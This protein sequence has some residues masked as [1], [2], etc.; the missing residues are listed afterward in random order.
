M[1]WTNPFSFLNSER[2][3]PTE[4]MAGDYGGR[5]LLVLND[6]A[7]VETVRE[8]QKRFG[9]EAAW[10]L[11]NGD[12]RYGRK[13]VQT[14]MKIARA[15]FQSDHLIDQDRAVSSGIVYANAC[16]FLK[17]GATMTG[18]T[19]GFSK[20]S[21]VFEASRKV[22]FHTAKK[23][24]NLARVLFCGSRNAPAGRMMPVFK[25]AH[26][27]IKVESTWH[28]NAQGQMEKQ[29]ESADCIANAAKLEKVGAWAS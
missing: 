19:A 16:F 28:P 15:L 17:G 4:A 23:M 5:L 2:L 6:F 10:K 22:L 24:P 14:N 25:Y 27:T 13:G 3:H 20:G 29:K 1:G 26:P 21:D 11:G 18:G 9:D 12:A 8:T 7:P